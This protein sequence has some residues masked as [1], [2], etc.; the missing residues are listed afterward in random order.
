MNPPGHQYRQT[1]L[2]IV[3][4]AMPE[5]APGRGPGGQLLAR[6][7]RWPPKIVWHTTDATGI[8]PSPA[9]LPSHSPLHP[10]HLSSLSTTIGMPN[11]SC[12]LKL[13]LNQCFVCNFLS[14]PRWQRQTVSKKTQSPSC[15]A[16]NF[17]NLLLTHISK[18]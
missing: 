10:L 9:G 8:P 16:C 11:R 7:Q 5:H 6:L 1:V 4:H 14:M 13:W 12:I 3:N 2:C 15:L 18:I 17:Q